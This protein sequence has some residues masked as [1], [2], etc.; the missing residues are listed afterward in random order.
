MGQAGQ[1]GGTSG[2]ISVGHAEYR[3]EGIAERR[4]D[5]MNDAR[6]FGHWVRLRRE[7]TR[8]GDGKKLS[9]KDL[10]G[11]VHREEDTVR[12]VESGRRRPSEELSKALVAALAEP[13][14][15]QDALVGWARGGRLPAHLETPEQ[16]EKSD[17]V[18]EIV[19][20]DGV[21]DTSSTEAS[22]APD[23]SHM[24]RSYPR[25][26]MAMMVI[27]ALLIIVGGVG[28]IA[29]ARLEG[30]RSAVGRGADALR[31]T[32]PAA[33]GAPSADPMVACG[34]SG[35]TPAT[36]ANR[37]LRPQG[38]SAFT[39][40]NTGGSV[41]NNKV[42]ELTIDR[43]GIW[44]GYF[45]TDSNHSSGVGYFDRKTW[46]TCGG[47]DGPSGQNINGV[48]VDRQ[49]WLWVATESAGVYVFDGQRWRAYRVRDGLPSD[50]IYTVVVDEKDNVW[51]GTW[52][53]VA[54]FDR[55]SWSTIYT[56]ENGTLMN[57]R[58][59][60]IAFDA[61]GNTWIG[62]IRQGGVSRRDAEGKW[63]H[64]P[65]GPGGPGGQEMRK[66]VVRRGGATVPESVWFASAD[67]G[68]SRFEQG[69]WT[70]FRVQ[71]GLL[72]DDVRSLATDRYN[73]VWA[74]TANGVVYFD[75]T[76]WNTY[77]T[78]D[79][80]SIA[81]GPTCSGCPYDDD[82]VW[83]GTTASGLTQSRIPLP[84]DAIDIIRVSYPGIVA[85]GERFRPEIVVAP[86]PPY[87]LR[88]DRGDFLS[89]TDEDDKSLFG[90]YPLIP[91]KGVID[92]AQQ[93]VFTDY[94]NL[95]Q[96]PSLP[97]GENEKTFTSTWRVWMFTRYVGPPIRITFTVRRQLTSSVTKAGVLLSTDTGDRSPVHG[98]TSVP[99]LIPAIEAIG[100]CEPNPNVGATRQRRGRV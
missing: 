30:S 35:R 85:P 41:L 39:V 63:T 54:R 82:H 12:A 45:G 34:E 84:D 29:E 21:R 58:V 62:Y 89:N 25:R 59:H 66:V 27:A 20:D 26:K 17:V 28:V 81:F 93:F 24:P 64:Y 78:L 79:T 90:S 22:D 92:S 18:L 51:V 11:L 55:T 94:E 16:G 49:G 91:A 1:F 88:Q 98:T 83:T 31:A 2:T 67:G 32:N 75:G 46:A 61:A 7:A 8:R 74:A 71:D 69:R 40:E 68:V 19:S 15:D 56:A 96:A 5:D 53:G 86:R 43:R 36:D 65:P 87:Q 33:V 9:Q 77:D 44:I 4:R 70:V 57:D 42:R 10:A 37:F 72:T 52:E 50:Q 23:T 60:A 80:Q 76:R 13:G 6:R 48:A 99:Q 100:E 14:E 3:C 47:A 73:R 95:F 38:V 97:E